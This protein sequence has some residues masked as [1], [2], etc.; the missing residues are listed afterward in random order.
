MAIEFAND[1]QQQYQR[2]L[3]NNKREIREIR[4]KSQDTCSNDYRIV[5]IL[6]CCCAHLLLLLLQLVFLKMCLAGMWRL[7]VLLIYLK[8]SIFS[9]D[10]KVSCDNYDFSTLPKLMVPPRDPDSAIGKIFSALHNPANNIHLASNNGTRCYLWKCKSEEFYGKEC[11]FCLPTVFVAGFSKC[12]TTALCS[13]LI[14]HPEIKQYR[15]KE[16]NIWTKFFDEFSWDKFEKRVLDTNPKV[17]SLVPCSMPP[18][19]SFF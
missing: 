1:N 15:K 5:V 7:V 9:V 14:L 18:S 3:T 13:K 11:K 19:V 6:S 2:V 10:A 12:G 17:R 8:G 4:N 16:I